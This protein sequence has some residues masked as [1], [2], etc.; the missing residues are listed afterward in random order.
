MSPSRVGFWPV[1]SLSWGFHPYSGR[2]HEGYGSPGGFHAT[3]TVRPQGSSPSRRLAPLR[4][5]RRLPAGPLLG[6][7]PSGPCSCRQLRR[8][9]EHVPNPP[10]VTHPDRRTLAVTSDRTRARVEGINPRA[11]TGRPSP[12][13]CCRQS[14]PLHRLFK[15]P[16]R[17]MP[18]W[19]SS[20]PGLSPPGPPNGRRRSLRS[21]A[22]AADRLPFESRPTMRLSVLPDP[23]VG[24]V[25]LET[26]SP[27]EVPPL[28]QPTDSRAT[29][30]LGMGSP[31][32][33]LPVAGPP[34][35]RFAPPRLLTGAQWVNLS[36][37]HRAT[38]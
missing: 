17:P 16:Q 4:A 24:V 38:P 7:Q 18:S 1:L 33:R 19:L 23:G 29:T 15:V 2:Q 6:F 5:F 3:S 26:A 32:G 12:G 10:D 31:R 30:V 22:F 9:F 8:P 20:S 14:V 28:G 37:P 11:K 35:P 36:G 21:R 27:P 25:S 34:A 13:P